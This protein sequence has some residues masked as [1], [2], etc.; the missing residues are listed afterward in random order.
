MVELRNL[1]T[2]VW[3]ARLGS[4]R[5]AAG[6]LNAAQPT[7]SARISRLEDELGV[8]LF[9]RTGRRA[10][11]TAKGRD[12]LLYA[13]QLLAIHGEMIAV[14]ADPEAIGGTVR[15]GLSETIVHTWLPTLINRLHDKYPAISLEIEVDTSM[16]LRDAL[17]G[18]ELD[19]AFLL[20]PV[21]Q[22]LIR[23]RPLCSY[24]L[25]WVASPKL[26]LPA[27]RL[28]L[29]QLFDWPV[30]TYPRLT[31]PY[32][33]VHALL[34]QQ[35]ARRPRLYSSSSLATIV[36]MTLDGIGISAIPPRIVG[37]ELRQGRLVT[38][39]C[40]TKLPVMNFTVCYPANTD[41]P[42]VEAITRLAVKVAAED[43]V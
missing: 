20:G 9:V 25:A 29:E 43:S 2:F 28:S 31:R 40:T 34:A 26:G 13:E 12:L 10:S 33:D 24:E 39:D 4:F 15:L 38:L 16:N 5:A 35:G 23:N 18:N 27:G 3:I 37:D 22:P 42:L 14:V 6:R 8:P 11:L 36:R 1:K 19:I 32:V 21:S 41:S 17:V 7:L 30:I